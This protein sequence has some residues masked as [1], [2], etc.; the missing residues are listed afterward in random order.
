MN[1]SQCS[2][3]RKIVW[4]VPCKKLNQMPNTELDCATNRGLLKLGCWDRRS[5]D[6]CEGGAGTRCGLAD[7]PT[8]A[9]AAPAPDWSK[10]APSG[11]EAANRPY[12]EANMSLL[13]C[14]SEHNISHSTDDNCHTTTT[15]PFNGPWSGTTRVGQYQKKHST[16]HTHPDH[17]TSFI[18]FL[19]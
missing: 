4:N 14:S 11:L 3:Y 9:P 2:V 1:C 7:Q 16:T 15:Q 6:T 17:R 19:H 12:S 10:L 13:R 8:G 18:N 5:V